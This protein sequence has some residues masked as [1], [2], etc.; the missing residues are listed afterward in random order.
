MGLSWI[1]TIYLAHWLSVSNE[2][3]PFDGMILEC[4][5]SSTLSVVLPEISAQ[6]SFSID[7]FPNYWNILV[8]EKPVFII[9]GT[10]DDVINH[11][12]SVKLASVLPEKSLYKFW[13][14]EGAGHDDICHFVGTD[15]FLNELRCFVDYC[16]KITI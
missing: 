7:M 9:H 11:S 2:K 3:N 14:I 4:P 16:K 12:A 13:S 10:Q 1:W 6:T 15:K 8:V 5:L